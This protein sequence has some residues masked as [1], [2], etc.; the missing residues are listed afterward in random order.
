[1]INILQS[2]DKKELTNPQLFS[3][4]IPC[5]SALVRKLVTIDF[6]KSP[7][8]DLIWRGTSRDFVALLAASRP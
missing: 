3:Y 7:S 4:V 5:F 6:Q 2:E 8:T 1:M